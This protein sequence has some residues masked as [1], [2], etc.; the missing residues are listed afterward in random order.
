MSNNLEQLK[1]ALA[2]R[3]EVEKEIGQGGM[4]TVYLA[5][6]VRHDR[7]VAIKV[8]RPELAA[9]IG[10]ERFV[11]EIKIAAKLQHPHI[12]PLLDSGDASGL[13]F[14]VMPF[15]KGESLRDYL[16]QHGELP[17]NDAIRITR[18]VVDALALAHHEGLVHRDVKPDNVMISGRHVMVTD[19]GVAKALSEAKDDS[20]LT[21]AGIALGTPTY[22]APEQATADPNT[23][24]RADLYAVGAMAYELLT[25]DPPFT[26]A[27]AQQVLS[28]HVTKEVEP[29]TTHRSSVSPALNDFVLRCL[30]KNPADRWQTAEEM[31][32]QL[33]MMSSTTGGMTPVQTRSSKAVAPAGHRNR[34]AAMIAAAVLGAGALA[35]A[36]FFLKGEE[37]PAPMAFAPEEQVTHRGDVG[38]VKISPD[39]NTLAYAVD[40]SRSLV[41]QDL[42]GGGT[43]TIF[44]HPDENRAVGAFHWSHDGSRIYFQARINDVTGVYSLPKLGG[45]PSLVND[46][47]E[48]RDTGK[49]F[50]FWSPTSDGRWLIGFNNRVSLGS[51]LADLTFV[52]EMTPGGDWQTVTVDLD[53]VTSAELS[54]DGN[55]IVYSS[56]TRAFDSLSNAVISLDG[57]TSTFLGGLQEV[58][59]GFA[60][61]NVAGDGIY[62]VRPTSGAAELLL[63]DFNPRD[64][65]IGDRT[66]VYPRISDGI[67]G[68]P[69]LSADRTK[70]VYSDAI[71]RANLRMM[72]FDGSGGVEEE[73]LTRG[74]AA[75]QFPTFSADGFMVFYLRQPLTFPEGELLYMSRSVDGG[76]ERTIGSGGLSQAMGPLAISPDGSRLAEFEVDLGSGGLQSQLAI[77]DVATGRRRTFETGSVL[78]GLAW[79]PDGTK[80]VGTEAIAADPDVEIVQLVDVSDGT[81]TTLVLPCDSGCGFSSELVVMSPEWPFAALTSDADL[82]IVNLEDGSLEAIASR[83]TLV[84]R[85]TS[86]GW[87]YFS[88]NNLSRDDTD[89]AALFR[90]R[91][92][93]TGE[94]LIAEISSECSLGEFAVSPDGSRA[95]CQ[96]A[97]SE[98]DVK[99]VTLGS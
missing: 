93:G 49:Q 4:A 87:I 57:E 91:A 61:W 90:I 20:N 33:E 72:A 48:F 13:L 71:S 18:E 44:T 26:G 40:E 1:E 29:V 6:D 32:G 79:T 2:G 47:Q 30:Q 50:T 95:V 35:A 25:G 63:L 5:N 7:Q 51:S 66:V 75:Y 9:T 98:P 69:D 28:A 22:M 94:E 99:L 96:V 17:I 42:Q 62:V 70:L 83:A 84:Y 67:V 10:A 52:D 85:W 38:V 78:V 14:Y 19:F 21:T 24:H 88:R 43:S 89:Q 65:S 37:A 64:G 39:G 45:T 46:L 23:D 68:T 15:I 73:M 59:F 27:N 36:G 55:W 97:E 12:L 77:T 11:R 53:L 60:R 41:I 80:V 34:S 3:Y 81:A 56:L 16:D 54:P 31:L 82:W 8:L 92:N 58:G 76:E 74:T 86:D